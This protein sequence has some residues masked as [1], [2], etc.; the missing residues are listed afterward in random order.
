MIDRDRQRELDRLT[1][2]F[3]AALDSGDLD[4]AEKLWNE[5]AADHEVAEAFTEAAAELVGEATAA[6]RSQADGIVEAVI[7]K[8]IPSVETIR[9]PCGPLTVG[10]VAEHL[11]RS[12]VPGLTAADFAVND[13]LA[14]CTDSLPEQLGL[15]AVIAWGAR[16]GSAPKIFWKAFREAALE[17]RLRRESAGDYQLAAR[18]QRPKRPGGAQ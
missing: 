9:L 12:G 15:S 14:R 2:L 16:F 11:R 13:V 17:L 5:A 7:R 8:A 1:A 6:A 10:D 18:P 4:S 3:L